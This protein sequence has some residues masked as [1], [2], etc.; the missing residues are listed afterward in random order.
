MSGL[1][2]ED[3][4]Q[5]FASVSSVCFFLSLSLHIRFFCIVSKLVVKKLSDFVSIR[6]PYLYSFAT[7]FF[8]PHELAKYFK[9]VG[10]IQK[11]IGSQQKLF[12]YSFQNNVGKSAHLASSLILAES[13]YI[14]GE[15]YFWRIGLDLV[16]FDLTSL[17]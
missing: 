2:Y 16:Y 1:I 17:T 11:K 7:T 13:Y 5:W 8:Q 10:Y 3:H 14:F 4:L 9:R 15:T 12:V 6:H